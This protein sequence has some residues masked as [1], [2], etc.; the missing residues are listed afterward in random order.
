[1]S[2]NF[3][4]LN[5]IIVNAISFSARKKNGSERYI[6]DWSVVS[7]KII[8]KTSALLFFWSQKSSS[9][10]VLPPKTRHRRN[11]KNQTFYP[12]LLSVAMLS[13][14]YGPN[15]QCTLLV[16]KKHLTSL[17]FFSAVAWWAKTNEFF[18]SV[19]RV[20]GPIV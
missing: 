5:L 14:L 6:L 17:A 2:E 8:I 20:A 12:V 16:V 7:F 11:K 10:F 9:S 13:T 1:M 18:L 15:C 19:S 4:Y 3:F